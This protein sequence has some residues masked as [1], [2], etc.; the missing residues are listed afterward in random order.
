[1]QRALSLHHYSAHTAAAAAAA[2]AR[3][4]P[5]SSTAAT[6]ATEAPSARL[7]GMLS[8]NR[9]GSG[10]SFGD[11][12]GGLPQQQQ[13]GRGGHAAGAAAAPT[14]M[15]DAPAEAGVTPLVAAITGDHGAVVEFLLSA[16]AD[17]SRACPAAV[18]GATPLGTAAKI[19]DGVRCLEAL[20]EAG[21]LVDGTDAAGNTPL[22]YAARSG[23]VNDVFYTG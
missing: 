18:G 8:S 15:D 19:P 16:R 10:G 6:G 7:A 13:L 23:Y 2:T 9:R 11:H 20:L 5:T 14:S 17:P 4:R 22:M 1:M 12:D 21:A 3:A